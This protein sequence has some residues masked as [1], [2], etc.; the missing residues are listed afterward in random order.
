MLIGIVAYS[1]YFDYKFNSNN[2]KILEDTN[3]YFNHFKND[4]SRSGSNS[5]YLPRDGGLANLVRGKKQLDN[6]KK[7]SIRSDEAITDEVVLRFDS[8]EEYLEFKELA[9]EKNWNIIGSIPAL[10]SYRLGLDKDVIDNLINEYRSITDDVDFNYVI[11]TPDIPES[12]VDNNPTSYKP[13]FNTA[14]DWIGV[15]DNSDKWGKNIKVAIL[16]TGIQKHSTLSHK[17]IV[18]INLIESDV[19]NDAISGHGTAVASIISGKS[20]DSKG[21][22]PSVELLSIRVLDSEGFGDVFTVAQGIVKAVDSGA[23][24]INLSLGHYTGSSVLKSAVDYALASNVAVVA[25]TGNDGVEGILYPARYEGVIG[26]AAVDA[27]GNRAIFSNYGEGIDLAA[28]GVGINTAWSDEGIV[29]FSGTSAAA[30]FVSGALAAIL[31]DNPVMTTGDALQI[32]TSNTNDSDALGYD[33]KIGFGV[34]DMERVVNRNEPNIYDAAVSDIILSYSDLENKNPTDI[35]VTI[36]NR[37]TDYL[38]RLK[39]EV[40][41]NNNNQIYYQHGLS[42]G[43]VSSQ[44][45]PLDNVSFE[46]AESILVSSRIFI[47]SKKDSKPDNDFKNVIITNSR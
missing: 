14:L 37:G 3:R 9:K 28:P 23:R 32:L 41:V 4:V 19:E 17:E 2:K 24:I 18:E 34:I 13:F 45:V 38:S 31:S 40:S 43:G 7:I 47:D 5:K 8:E 29:S 33:E 26:V 16:D 25:A 20:S 21:V 22:A 44:V 36:Q 10:R 1:L 6:Q 42:A 30:P 15:P 12:S 46:L 35:I 27:N 39:L 11:F